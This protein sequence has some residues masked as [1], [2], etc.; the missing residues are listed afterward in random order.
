MTSKVTI[1]NSFVMPAEDETFEVTVLDTKSLAPNCWL[2]NESV[3]YLEVVNY[4][5]YNSTITV[6]NLGR[7]ENA[8]RGTEFPTCMEFLVTA[9]TALDPYNPLS[10]CLAADFNS[11]AVGQ[12]ALMSVSSTY[13]IKPDDQI[14]VDGDYRYAVVQVIN[15]TTLKVL[16][17]GLGKEGIIE[18]GCDSCVPVQVV[19]KLNCCPI[20]SGDLTSNTPVLSVTDGYD[21]L[22]DNASLTLD[23][24]LS[25]YDNSSSEFITLNDVPRGTLSSSSTLIGVTGGA[26]NVLGNISLSLDTDLSKYNNSNSSFITVVDIPRGE[27][28]SSTNVLTVNNG[29]NNVLSNIE[30]ILDKDLSKYNNTT[31][32]FITLGD[33]P[34]GTLSSSTSLLTVSGGTNNVLDNISLTL[35][36]DLNNYDN[37]NSSFLSSSDKKN[38]TSTT[39]VLTVTN[40]TGAVLESTALTLNTDL[41]QYD[42]SVSNFV[43]VGGLPSGDLSSVTSVLT[44]SGGNGA[45]LTNSTLTLDTDLSKYDNTISGFIT[46]VSNLDDIGDVTLTSPQDG[47]VL[48]YDAIS[49]N[50]I[51]STGGGGGTYTATLPISIDAN[52]DISISQASST[53]DGYLSSVDWNTFNSKLTLDH[54]EETYASNVAA[55]VPKTS[56]AATTYN[57]GAPST[58]FD[59]IFVTGVSTSNISSLNNTGTIAIDDTIYPS[60]SGL[61]LGG[62]LY[63]WDEAYIDTIKNAAGQSTIKIDADLIPDTS[64]YTLGTLTNPWYGAYIGATHI[65]NTAILP[66]GATYTIGDSNT[67]WYGAYIGATNITDSAILPSGSS[68]TIGDSSAQWSNIYADAITS[69]NPPSGNFVISSTDRLYLKSYST[70]NTQ[71]STLV[72]GSK[73]VIPETDLDIDLGATAYRYNNIYGHNIKLSYNNENPTISS[74]AR[75]VFTSFYGGSGCTLSLRS[76]TLCPDNDNTT[77]LGVQL[78]G[79]PATYLAYKRVYSYG[80]PTVSDERVKRDIEPLEDGLSTINDL[81][82]KSY[83]FNKHQDFISYGVLAQEVVDKHPEL[84]DTAGEGENRSYSVYLQNVV[85]LAVKAIQ[86]LSS[87]VDE[88]NAKIAVLERKL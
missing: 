23:T 86:E 4:S 25:K 53:T 82:V 18:V 85:Y 24:D 83:T 61:N 60:T 72:L 77:D 26:N 84:V 73:R 35:D 32:A 80:Y 31:S 1:L 66:S 79:T 74:D 48:V 65:S 47:D 12:T 14:I 58:A 34:R 7:R 28:Y 71:T 67:Y 50:W 30:L 46:G 51:N 27:L 33:I 52:N 8:K 22:L 11:P 57:L 44:V 62:P 9:P 43:T 49:G 19:S 76:N 45:V 68:L 38:L 15:A 42:N 59:S 54:F 37:T 70:D 88:L 87:K 63:A 5:L 16:N 40:G 3:G 39:S 55:F 81:N 41:S 17:E 13:V 10:T 20:P 56:S 75:L 29:A 78:P 69:N 64:T 21:V 36:T 2:W 6:K